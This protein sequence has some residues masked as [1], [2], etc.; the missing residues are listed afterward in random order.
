M[1]FLLCTGLLAI[2]SSG[3]LAAQEREIPKDSELVT[4]QG[5]ARGRSFTVGERRE[6]Q[7]GT[8]AIAEGRRF[9]LNGPKK[10]LDEIRAHQRTT[11]E[12]TGLVRKSDLAP[13]QGIAVLG[14]R[15]RIGGARVPQDPVTNPQRNPSYTQT[16]IDVR[17]WRTLSGDCPAR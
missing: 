13:P 10:L 6:D 1:K 14:G 3:L 8:L 15:L 5:C 7:P 16:T 4:I 11:V 2:V 12:V 17:S 9:R